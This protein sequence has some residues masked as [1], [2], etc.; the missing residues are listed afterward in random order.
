MQTLSA[1]LLC[2]QVALADVIVINKLDLV[3]ETELHRLEE[4]I[5]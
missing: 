3:S 1:S 5:R 2:R 4:E